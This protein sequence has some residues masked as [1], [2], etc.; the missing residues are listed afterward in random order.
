MSPHHQGLAVLPR[1][2]GPA[3]PLHCQGYVRS[4]Y[5]VHKAVATMSILLSLGD[6]T[7]LL[8]A[9]GQEIVTKSQD[10]DHLEPKKHDLVIFLDQMVSC[11][12]CQAEGYL[13]FELPPICRRLTPCNL[14]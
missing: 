7:M 4:S 13:Y 1:D 3:L 12:I 6:L 8:V 11:Y 5:Y 9:L 14:S 10:Q 2:Q